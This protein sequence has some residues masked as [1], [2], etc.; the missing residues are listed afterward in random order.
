MAWIRCSERVP[1]PETEVLVYVDGH[2]GP[3]WSN[4]HCLVAYW[5]PWADEWYEERHSETWLV[6]VTHWQPLPE[7]PND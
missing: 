3:S 6:G 1:E 7:P 4:N 2:R 5:A